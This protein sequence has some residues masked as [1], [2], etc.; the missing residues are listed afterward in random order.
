MRIEESILIDRTPDEVFDFLAVRSNDT[1][2]MDSV[3]ESDWLEPDVPLGI[4]RRGRMVQKMMG[5]RS[6]YI[7]EISEF[8]PGRRIAHRTVEGPIDLNT[9]CLTDPVDG[10]TRVTVVAETDAFVRGPLAKVANP[11]VAKLVRRSFRSDLVRLKDVL[12]SGN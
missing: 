3:K 5:R 6:E 1:R 10:G 8:E 4:G 7:D 9:A 12:G 11:I 2:W